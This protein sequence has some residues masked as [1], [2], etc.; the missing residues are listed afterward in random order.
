MQKKPKKSQHKRM[1]APE[2]RLMATSFT[3]NFRALLDESLVRKGKSK[4]LSEE[5]LKNGLFLILKAMRKKEV[6]RK[7]RRSSKA[8]GGLK[9][10]VIW[11]LLSMGVSRSKIA[12]MTGMQKSAVQRMLKLPTSSEARKEGWGKLTEE[13]RKKRGSSGKDRWKNLSEKKKEAFRKKMAR[14]GK[15][16]TGGKGVKRYWDDISNERVD[17]LLSN[18][19]ICEKSVG[20]MTFGKVLEMLKSKSSLYY[21]NVMED[22]ER[23]EFRN[24]SKGLAE[25]D[26]SAVNHFLE[27]IKPKT[28]KD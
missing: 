28:K 6:G 23:E 12:K 4:R 17:R 18:K 8:F 26:K 10:N 1:I 7:V 15:G 27:S 22:A 9:R 24:I 5:E 11:Q 2:E 14:I 19:K 25:E 13:E 16:Q 21:F 3:P 20:R